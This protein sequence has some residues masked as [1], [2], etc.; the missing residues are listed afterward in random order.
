MI[1]FDIVY[2]KKVEIDSIKLLGDSQLRQLKLMI[3]GKYQIYDYSHIF[4]YYKNNKI[5][6]ND[7]TKLKEIFK[8]KK[9]KIE[10]TEKEKNNNNNSN[11]IF[12][13]KNLCS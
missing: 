2:K 8:S 6:S 9:E 12:I 13:S 11:K 7:N 3:C 4:I 1:S 10:I 5:I